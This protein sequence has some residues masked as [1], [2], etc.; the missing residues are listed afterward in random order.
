MINSLPKSLIDTATKMLLEMANPTKEI[1]SSVFYHG[2]YD[3][4]GGDGVEHASN[5]ANSGIVPPDLEGKKET[6]L[7]P[8]H[9]HTY[10]TPDIGYAQMYALG[11]NFAGHDFSDSNWKPKHTYGYIFSFSGKRLSDVQPDEDSVGELYGRGK[12]PDFVNELAKKHT[13]IRTRNMTKEGVY[14]YY[15]KLGKQIIPHMTDDQ[16]L[17]LIHK[18]GAH[19]ANKGSITPDRVYRIPMGKVKHLNR[20]GSNFFDHAEELDMDKLKEGQVVVSRKR[21]P[22]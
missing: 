6:H 21:K 12:V 18:H 3:R 11:G 15:A 16:K 5:I 19:V 1:K 22:L 4:N 2:T 14:S 10:S 17:E 9:G 20:D 13:T 7:T 8:V